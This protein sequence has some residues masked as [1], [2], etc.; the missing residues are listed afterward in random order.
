ME[1]IWI[2][3]YLFFTLLIGGYLLYSVVMVLAIH[4]HEWATGAHVSPH[5]EPSLSSLPIPSLWLSQSTGFWV[6][7]FLHWTYTVTLGKS[8]L[9]CVP[10]SPFLDFPCGSAGKEFTWNV[11]DLGSVSWLGRLPG[12]RKSYPLQYS[13]LEN[14]M[15]CIVQGVTKS[16]TSEQLSLSFS[17]FP[18]PSHSQPKFYLS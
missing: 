18:I 1:N 17:T 9:F 8:V 13:G 7:W 2:E 4:W 14:S 12:E 15:D 6:S 16:R 11:E 5:R 10:I 3:C